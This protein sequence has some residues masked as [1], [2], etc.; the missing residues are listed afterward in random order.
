MGEQQTGVCDQ[1]RMHG[2]AADGS[3]RPAQAAFLPVTHHVYTPRGRNALQTICEKHFQ[4]YCNV[5]EESYASQ[6]GKFRL[7]RVM[8]VGEHFLACGD[9]LQRV[10][11]IKCTNPD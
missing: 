7:D 8:E 11:R 10:A 4:E 6:Y 3:L 2:R 9:Y 1:P 5:Y